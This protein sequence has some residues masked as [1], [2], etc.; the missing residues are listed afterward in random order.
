MQKVFKDD[1]YVFDNWFRPMVPSLK[2]LFGVI[3]QKVQAAKGCLKVLTLDVTFI[4]PNAILESLT[5]INV[6]YIFI[7]SK[8]VSSS[9]CLT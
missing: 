6:A 2:Y 8:G 1:D 9:T 5:A 7:G 3:Y 4:F